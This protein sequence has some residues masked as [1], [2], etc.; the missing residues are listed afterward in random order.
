MDTAC[1]ETSGEVKKVYK[2][3]DTG[4]CKSDGKGDEGGDEHGEHGIIGHW[5]TDGE[6]GDSGFSI[7][8]A[9]GVIFPVS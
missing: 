8:Q 3:G 4:R 9:G 7:A 5:F 1:G 2:E 6:G